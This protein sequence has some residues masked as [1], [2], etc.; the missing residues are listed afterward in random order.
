V[1]IVR[2]SGKEE[3]N[4]VTLVLIYGHLT[5]FKLQAYWMWNLYAFLFQLAS[6]NGK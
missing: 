1:G 4:T 6:E 2:V 5:Q 3:I